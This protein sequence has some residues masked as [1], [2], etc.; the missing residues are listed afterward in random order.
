MYSKYISYLFVATKDAGYP[1]A[2]QHDTFT[3]LEI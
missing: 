1:A 2:S 3:P